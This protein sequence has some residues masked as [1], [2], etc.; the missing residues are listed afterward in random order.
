VDTVERVEILRDLRLGAFDVLV[1]INLLREGLDIPEVSLVA[2]LDA[3]K[4]G[5]LRNERSLVQ[6][7]GRAAR[8]V[9]GKVLMY[10]DK[11]TDSMRKTMEETARRRKLQTEF[12]EMHGLV[13]TA[14]NKSKEKIME[15]T[16]VADG[17]LALRK[18][19]YEQ[20]EISAIAAEEISSY[21]NPNELEKLIK[22]TR[23]AMEKAA[24]ELDFI[25]AARLRDILFE[26]EKKIK[27][28][29]SCGYLQ[30]FFSM[31]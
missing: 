9:N 16:K 22:S 11:I 8:N 29:S 25:E 30:L 14:L 13:P 20:P 28:G 4:E 3:D 1:G 18:A 7:V 24:K 26:L 21:G 6:T 27:N 31:S 19:K 5:F 2:I 23:K 12:N 17:D 10:A 15:S